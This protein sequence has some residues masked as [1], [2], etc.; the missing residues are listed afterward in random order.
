MA[1]SELSSAGNDLP[2]WVSPD[3]CTILVSTNRDGQHDLYFAR[4][5]K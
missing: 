5:P 4:R 3:D 2:A 1:V